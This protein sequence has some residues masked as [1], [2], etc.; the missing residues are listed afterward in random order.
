[1]E[2][3]PTK[4]TCRNAKL[5]SG[6][7]FESLRLLKWPTLT[8]SAQSASPVLLAQSLRRRTA[9]ILL[10]PFTTDHAQHVGQGNTWIQLQGSG[11]EKRRPSLRYKP[12]VKS[13]LPDTSVMIQSFLQLEI[14]AA[15]LA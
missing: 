9:A 4:T 2:N 11:T 1:M 3:T 6:V 10:R 13:V 5:A 8:G 7:N 12:T 15:A 14:L